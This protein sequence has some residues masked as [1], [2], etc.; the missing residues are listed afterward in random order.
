M[1][2]RIGSHPGT[3]ALTAE[4]LPVSVPVGDGVVPIGV[5]D[6]FSLYGRT[7]VLATLRAAFHDA[8]AGRGSAVVVRG[9][10]GSG[11]SSVLDAV[12]DTSRDH[13]PAA[14]SRRHPIAD[15]A[16]HA[17]PSESAVPYSGL[18]RLLRPL[19]D[20]VP[21]LPHPQQVA[22]QRVLG[23][24]D[25]LPDS[26]L[27]LGTAVH[28][29]LTRAAA[30][31]TLLCR[32]DDAGFLDRE[33]LA[34]VA[35]AARRVHRHA[36]LVVLTADDADRGTAAELLSDLP[37]VVLAPLDDDDAREFIA[38]RLRSHLAGP[39][40]DDVVAEL[41]ELSH[42]NPLAIAELTAAL[43]PEQIQ[44]L[45]PLPE[46]LPPG[47]SLRRR[48]AERLRS[49]PP[50]ARRLVLT[51]A[52]AT[53]LDV[54]TTM[55]ITHHPSVGAEALD[56]AQAAGVV[57]VHHEQVVV[58][59]PLAR[60]CFYTGAPLAERLAAHR[61]LADVLD[62]ERHHVERTWHRAAGTTD[63]DDTL[64][65]ELCA[66]AQLAA[67]AGD[68][69]A[70]SRCLQRSAALTTN[71]GRAAERLVTAARAAWLTG[72]GRRARR[73]LAQARPLA[74]TG[75][76]RGLVDLLRGEIE[77]RSGTA[78]GAHD[79][80]AAVAERF[81]GPHR[82]QAV[83][84]LMREIERCEFA[85]EHPRL[86]E[87]A[88][89]FIH[90]RRGDELPATQLLFDDFEGLSA[91]YQGDHRR[92]VGSLRSVVDLAASMRDPSALLLGTGAALVMGDL[93]AA[94]RLGGQAAIEARACDPAQLPFALQLLA[95]TE[96][97]TDR[98][99]EATA[100]AL[101]GL[102]LARQSG[103]ENSA[104][105]HLSVLSLLAAMRGD[106]EAVA[107]SAVAARQAGARGLRRP[108]AVTMWAATRLALAQDRPDGAAAALRS[109]IGSGR[110]GM[111]LT[112]RVIATPD[113]VEAAAYQGE[114][115]WAGK[116]LTVFEEWA[117][118]MGSVPMQALAARC[119]ALLAAD[120]EEADERFRTAVELHDSSGM[121]FER[122][123]TQLLHGR[124][125]RR[126][127]RP[128]AARAPLHEALEA[129]E[130]LEATS[131]ASRARSEL[132][133][134]GG[135][136]PAKSSAPSGRT[137]VRELTPQQ[138]QIARLVA[139]GATNREIAA[140][141]FLSPRTVDHHLRNVF[142]RLGVRSRVELARVLS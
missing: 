137:A 135:A 139:G 90:L 94:H 96:F 93:A 83:T 65:D 41:A 129:F 28:G 124:A 33:S 71:G 21:D 113:F 110:R 78:E 60:E 111:H 48:Y 50:P 40:P 47:S 2:T 114:R 120:D 17:A 74:G 89:R 136:V 132:R 123:R 97:L 98:F 134:A 118:G 82:T 140:Q 108:T 52:A 49:L 87:L 45:E 15:L 138:E 73:L 26:Q 8:Q 57:Q 6:P 142:A 38:C 35:F 19:A 9:A 117:D 43:C 103:Q 115:E 127:R 69:A 76:L 81:S 53:Q 133:A 56:A 5:R 79:A 92:A 29:L 100:H 107:N 61:L 130:A 99:S 23:E 64:A 58:A 109:V 67:G 39:P 55:R 14:G 85:G 16:I 101:E 32:I 70:A 119:H 63:L 4:D 36:V 105:A 141:L 30:Q 112:V 37:T 42:G 59:D 62:H 12:L 7:E 24:Q 10:P 80:L 18:N 88:R 11:R 116:A 125:L 1:A 25:G 31:R 72:N 75:E 54:D 106:D 104:A 13:G 68:H 102:R 121:A 20:L 128:G 46:E 27:V 131:W 3:E 126:R 44:G 66:A 84:A 51:L 86:L 122:A 95:F 34:A 77:L 22:V 91:A